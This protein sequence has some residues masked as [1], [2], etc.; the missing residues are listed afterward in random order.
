MSVTVR[1]S[2]PGE[3]KFS[4]RSKPCVNVSDICARF[5]GGGHAMAAGCTIYTEPGA[6]LEQMLRAID[7]L[8]PED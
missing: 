6:A 8:W 2:R 5:G 4:L 3:S 7:E 1:E